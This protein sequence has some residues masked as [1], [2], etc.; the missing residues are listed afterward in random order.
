LD[1]FQAKLNQWPP[2]HVARIAQRVTNL[3]CAASIA[4]VT[5]DP[6]EGRTARAV[7]DQLNADFEQDELERALAW[8]IFHP[9]ANSIIT[10]APELD[11]QGNGR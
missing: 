9:Q 3:L 7:F 2:A 11:L 10:S 4:D 5:Q 6:L 8:V 1:E